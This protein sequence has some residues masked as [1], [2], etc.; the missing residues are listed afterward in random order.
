MLVGHSHLQIYQEGLQE[1][2]VAVAYWQHIKV[3]GAGGRGMT[4][5]T[6]ARRRTEVGNLLD[7]SIPC[8]AQQRTKFTY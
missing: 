4:D 2:G 3:E 6:L 8:C 1:I 7:A 5:G